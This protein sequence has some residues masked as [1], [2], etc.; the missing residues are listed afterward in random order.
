MND[1]IIQ[2]A[3]EQAADAGRATDTTLAHLT[4]GEVVI[5]KP[6]MDDPEV[7]QVIQALFDAYGENMGEFTVGDPANKIN[8]ETGYP[9]FFFK[10]LKKVFKKVAP[11][12]LP[13]LGSLVAPGIGTALGST[14][15]KAALMGIGGALGGGAGGAVSGG[16][17]KGVLTGAALGGAGGY[18]GGGGLVP[19]LGS[20][21]G[22]T[23]A[24]GMGPIT[25]ASGILGSVGK[26]LGVGANA[27]GAFGTGA[28]TGGIGGTSSFIRPAGSILSGVMQTNDQDEMERQ[29]LE[30]QGRAE[31]ALQPYSETGLKAQNQLS[32]NLTQGFDT[33]G[34]YDDPGYQYRLQQ[35]QQA[36]EKSLAAQGMGQSGA[37]MRAAQEL[38]QGMA[39]QQYDTAYNQWLQ[40]NQQ[41][42][43][44]GGSGQNA[45]TNIAGIY[46]TMGDVQANATLGRGNIMSNTIANVLGSR[47]IGYDQNGKPI[48]G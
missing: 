23:G 25:P 41:L 31:G 8:P 29:L 42:A 38:G 34:L 2:Q 27:A 12:A 7:M 1:M 11:I 26:T 46:G 47:I 10:K 36:L 17:I 5:P 35:G 39:A 48:Y 20:I 37:A 15:G 22:A 44:V 16:G 40:R 18:I 9:E 6:M 30:A 32:E 21:G 45:A 3:L 4:L 43:G 24:G 13:I 28:S 14:L 33:T 19:G